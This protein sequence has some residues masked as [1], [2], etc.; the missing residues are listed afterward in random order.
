[1][2]WGVIPSTFYKSW[3]D[4]SSKLGGGGGWWCQG[5]VDDGML[6]N[7]F[8]KDATSSI[9]DPFDYPN[10]TSSYFTLQKGH[11]TK[12]RK[13]VTNMQ[14][15]VYVANTHFVSTHFA[16]KRTRHQLDRLGKDS[17]FQKTFQT[18]RL[19]STI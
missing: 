4:P 13:R 5:R 12:A 10:W 9:R 6:G 2:A 18:Q 14:N 11:F 7:L 15:L 3:D 17:G 1:M 16:K 8:P 19:E